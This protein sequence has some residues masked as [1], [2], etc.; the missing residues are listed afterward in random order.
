MRL[1]VFG[2]TFDPIHNGHL[3][4]A[5]EVAESLELD[6][7]LFIPAGVPWLK[8]GTE[9]TD[10]TRRLEMV[11]LGIAGNGR[12]R[13]SDMEERRPGPSYTD[14]T[15]EELAAE[16]GG[17]PDI[18]LLVG[19]DALSE[20][21]RWHNPQRVL[22]LATIVGIPRPGCEELDRDA[23]DRVQEGAAQQVVLVKGTMIGI[24]GTEIRRRVSRGRSIRYLV[25]E[26]VSEYIHDH[27]LYGSAHD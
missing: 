22:Q 2:G 6:Q 24:K 16:S 19:L 21:D 15:L 27:G 23:L 13:P 14:D 20:I 12:F 10:P 3:I 17:G 25:P 11:R 1:G 9:V 7:V 5:D 8:Q 18:H 26:P 4:V